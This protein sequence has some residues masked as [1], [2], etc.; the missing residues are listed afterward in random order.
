MG[1][2]PKSGLKANPLF[3]QVQ[4]LADKLYE[5]YKTKKDIPKDLFLFK[6][7]NLNMWM[8]RMKEMATSLWTAHT[9][10]KGQFK[11]AQDWNWWKNQRQVIIGLDLSLT[12]D[13]TAVTFLKYDKEKDI[14]YAKNLV[15][16]PKNMEEKKAKAE[17]IPYGTWARQGYCQPI[18]E[19]VVDYDQLA[20]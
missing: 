13:N 18:G 16:Y 19:D 9:L 15:F 5:D 11:E 2:Y 20:T 6:V 14:Y 10:K 12:T 1:N 8:E 3:T 17:R 7:K 4:E